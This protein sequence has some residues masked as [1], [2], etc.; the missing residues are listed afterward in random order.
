[1]VVLCLIPGRQRQEGIC[2]IEA[3]LAYRVSSRR[4]RGGG[5]TFHETG[6]AM[7]VLLLEFYNFDDI[8]ILIKSLKDTIACLLVSVMLSNKY[9]S[10]SAYKRKR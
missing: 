3:R 6:L 1:M 4:A 10:S 7:R 8:Q 2:E 9:M 5:W